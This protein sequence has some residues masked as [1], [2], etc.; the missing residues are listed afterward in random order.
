[1][2]RF[3]R[4][5]SHVAVM[6]SVLGVGAQCAQ[7]QYKVELRIIER[8]GQTVADP[9]DN[10]L[11]FAVQARVTNDST[12]M[13]GGVNLRVQMPGEAQGRGTLTRGI[14]SNTDG[15]YSNAF[16]T[17]APGTVSGLAAQYRHLVSLNSGFNGGVNTS[18][19]P[20]LQD[21]A[22]QD[23]VGIAPYSAGES[24]T[25]VPGLFTFDENT[26][27]PI[28]PAG[29]QV[30]AAIGDQY[31]G[32]RGNWVDIYRFRYIVTDLTSRTVQVTPWAGT[33]ISTFSQLAL[34]DTLWG[35]QIT[36]D[37]RTGNNLALFGTSFEV[38]PAPASGA[39]LGLGAMVAIRRRR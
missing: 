10:T 23:I 36:T 2:A 3:V 20:E 37:Q 19:G 31:F 1:M 7:A 4:V 9:G 35:T 28:G 11:D 14:I 17:S 13:F 32:A 22:M 15:T 27:E 16:G 24:L 39:L 26:G 25:G 12:R 30:P 34:Q 33:T 8:T 18:V 5:S 21:P 6:A 38:I 29:N